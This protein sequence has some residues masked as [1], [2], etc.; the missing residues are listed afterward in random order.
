M[1]GGKSVVVTAS[2]GVGVLNREKGRSDKD[3]FKRV[4]DLC[5]KAKSE[6][7]NRVC[8]ANECVV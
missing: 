2:I 3:L 5:Y 6:G 8:N 4:D 7:R 1:A